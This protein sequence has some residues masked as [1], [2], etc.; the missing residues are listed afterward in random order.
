MSVV[1]ASVRVQPI[2]STVVYLKEREV[3]LSN[4]AWRVAIV[5]SPGTYEETASIIRT[6]AE[7]VTYFDDRVQT[8]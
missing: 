1:T 8:N 7:N 3:I 5:I 2:N 6:E 4:D